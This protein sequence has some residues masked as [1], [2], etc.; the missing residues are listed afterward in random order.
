MV[1]SVSQIVGTMRNNAYK[2]WSGTDAERANIEREQNSLASQYRS[3]TGEN[4]YSD[5]GFWYR[6]DGSRL[7][8]LN[9]DDVAKAIVAKMKQ[10][11]ALWSAA[12]ESTRKALADENVV[13]GTRLGDY[14]GASVTRDANGVWWI[15]GKK[16]YDI[17]HAGG[18]VGDYPTLKQNEV[19]AILEK[20]EAVLDE[21][22]ERGLYKIV[23]F[24][25]VLSEKLGTALD[26]NLI[27]K[28]FGGAYFS[29]LASP[30]GEL[31]K[32]VSGI[33]AA[34]PAYNIER[35]EVTA[36]IQVVQKLDDDAIK[37]HAK[38]IGT[39]SAK[40]IEEGFSKRGVKRDP[41]LF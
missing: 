25:S 10:N 24:I 33:T 8:N 13:L 30:M 7:F 31:S 5:N 27:D 9:D 20:G 2:W 1:D 28:A 17:Y 15:N 34:A 26:H 40:Y 29:G 36:P 11:S 19:M 35:I 32:A 6:A 16:L 22:R 14:L 3:L 37:Q 41:S 39:L 12:N 4:I 23:D 18:I 38:I 21:K